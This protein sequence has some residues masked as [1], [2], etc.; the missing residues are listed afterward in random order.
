MCGVSNVES[1]RSDG[2]DRPIMRNE[3]AASDPTEEFFRL[4]ER[5]CGESASPG[6][7][8]VVEGERD[9]ASLRKLGLT[10]EIVKLHHGRALSAT[11]HD[12][13]GRN[14][15]VIV[16]TDWD[17][18]GGHLAQRLREFLE[19]DSLELDLEFRRRLA[20]IVRG[21]LVHVEGLYSWARRLAERS[22]RS[23][24]E[25]LAATP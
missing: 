24:D 14:R 22:G 16:L 3:R 12:L 9:R 25:M 17:A 13:A 7:V 11:A 6:T 15:R 21:E 4:W 18:E 19:A 5:L 10:G 1:S 23:L 2:R 20:R 8:V